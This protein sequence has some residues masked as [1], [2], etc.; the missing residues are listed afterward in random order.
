M[1]ALGQGLQNR[2]SLIAASSRA[3]PGCARANAQARRRSSAS[4]ASSS[5]GQISG[6]A[7]NRPCRWPRSRAGSGRRRGS[8]P[9]RAP[10]GRTG[11]RPAR[12]GPTRAPSRRAAPSTTSAATRA[13][14]ARRPR[15][16]ATTQASSIAG[17]NSAHDGRTSTA[18]PDATPVSNAW[19]GPAGAEPPRRPPA[20]APPGPRALASIS[21]TK[22]AS[23]SISAEVATTY[24][25]NAASAA[26]TSGVD[27][28]H[29]PA[30][31]R[32][33]PSRQPSTRA[34]RPALP[35]PPGPAGPASVRSPKSS[36]QSARNSG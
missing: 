28:P 22:T 6:S 16:L 21:G 34:R 8:P 7:M 1:S 15:P 27:H 4:C 9:S 19:T 11:R 35:A 30:A 17:T 20:R 18:A 14:A 25:S 31:I 13:A 5:S 23:E 33:H 29:R 24:G 32:R 36:R 26:A 3:R 2:A 12:C 10:S